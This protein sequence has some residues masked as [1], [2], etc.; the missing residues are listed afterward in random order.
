MPHIYLHKHHT[1]QKARQLLQ[2]A[3]KS[4]KIFRKKEC[5]ICRHSVQQLAA[6]QEMATDRF[7]FT[8][9]KKRY[10][11]SAHHYNYFFPYDVWWLCDYCHT[12]LHKAQIEFQYVCLTP[13]A[14]RAAVFNFTN[15]RTQGGYSEFLIKEKEWAENEL[16]LLEQKRQKLLNYINRLSAS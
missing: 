16:R 1:K 5:E 11:L 3:V 15:W 14:A 10:P 12:V 4:G 8:E 9:H 13:E 7:N 6:I 2:S